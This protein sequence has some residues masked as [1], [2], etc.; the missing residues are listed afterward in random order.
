[1]LKLGLETTMPWEV[2]DA[3][4]QR[5]NFVKEW[6]SEEWG[7]AELCREY[8]PDEI[9]VHFHHRL[10]SIHPFPNG[11][12]RHARLMA[13]HLVMRLERERFSWGRESLRDAGDLRHRY[14]FALK[15]ATITISVRC[16]L[17]HAR[18]RHH[19]VDDTIQYRIGDAER[20]AL[21]D[22]HITQ[23][24]SPACSRLPSFARQERLL[25]PRKRR[26]GTSGRQDSS[27]NTNNHLP[28]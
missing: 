23:G 1:L 27:P 25:G 4:K 10:V 28:T 11:N 5:W 12:G 7:F 26:L 21:T 13:D 8:R 16:W 6:E 24:A 9:A 3:V 20:I 19:D 18:S 2:N 14:I 17:S 15:A 22:G